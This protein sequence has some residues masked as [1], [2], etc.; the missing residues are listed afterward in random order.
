MNKYILLSLASFLALTS[1]ETA[2]GVDLET[3]APK[4]VVDAAINW[5]KGT[6]G[7]QQHIK[8][9][10]TTGYFSPV[11]PTVSGAT[12]IVKNSSDTEFTFADSGNGDYVCT[13]FEPVIGETYTL[14]INLGGQVFTATETLIDVPVID[15]IEQKTETG[16]GQDEDRIDVKTFFTDP[17][18]TTD[19]YMTRI[20]TN[21]NAIP[22][23][24]VTDDEFFNGNQV[25]DL[26]L[27]QDIKPGNFM[28]I[29]LYGISERYFNYMAILTAMAEGGGPFGTPPATLRGNIKNVGNPSNFVLGYFSLSEVDKRN[30]V[31]Y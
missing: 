8:L 14:T 10:T 30:Y 15:K 24:H 9:S 18:N 7:H 22:T 2:I 5:E 3:A 20:Q 4:L 13:D 19:F 26:Y 27:N 6:D 12:V 25:F 1:C 29:R 11:I 31:V 28:E 16:I 17:A 21:I 23:F